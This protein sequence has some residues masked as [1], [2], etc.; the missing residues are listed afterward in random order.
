[1]GTYLFVRGT[2][3]GRRPSCGHL[4][5][6]VLSVGTIASAAYLMVQLQ[7]APYKNQ[8]DN[9]LAIASSFSLLMSCKW[10]GAPQTRNER[11]NNT[12]IFI[13][14]GKLEYNPRIYPDFFLFRTNACTYKSATNLRMAVHG[15]WLQCLRN[16]NWPW[17]RLSQSTTS[18]RTGSTRG[19]DP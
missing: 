17:L 14:Q 2:R 12:F 19:G 1:M 6:M 3:R 8:S 18:Q 15:A 10:D 7:A 5:I 9:Y 11:I 4:T 13:H 16:R